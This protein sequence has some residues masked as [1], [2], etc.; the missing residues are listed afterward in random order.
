MHYRNDF[1]ILQFVFKVFS[2]LAQPF[3]TPPGLCD[4]QH[5]ILKCV[6]YI[7]TSKLI[8]I[9]V[10]VEFMAELLHWIGLDLS[11]YMTQGL[12]NFSNFSFSRLNM[13]KKVLA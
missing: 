12:I 5:I 3:K 13:K 1:K 6:L 9:F 4:C 11:V 2:R 10:K 7:Q 8:I